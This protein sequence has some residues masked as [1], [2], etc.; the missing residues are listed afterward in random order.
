MTRDVWRHTHS[1]VVSLIIIPAETV[2]A[3]VSVMHVLV[4]NVI[5][6]HVLGPCRPRGMC[7]CVGAHGHAPPMRLFSTDPRQSYRLRRTSWSPEFGPSNVEHGH[8]CVP[9]AIAGGAKGG[10]MRKSRPR[11]RAQAPACVPVFTTPSW[12]VSSLRAT[13]Q[14]SQYRR[15]QHSYCTPG[16]SCAM[17][18]SVTLTGPHG[19]MVRTSRASAGIANVAIPHGRFNASSYL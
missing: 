17:A 4:S 10:P 16:A 18:V 19:R 7:L 1:H 14:R 12:Q 2:N 5:V 9:K 8:V 6:L 15:Q 3:S 13:S 11:L